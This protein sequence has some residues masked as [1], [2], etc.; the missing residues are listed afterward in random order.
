[1]QAPS[2]TSR[3]PI[4][5]LMAGAKRARGV[6]PPL[7]VPS[8]VV[9][10]E[11]C[12]KLTCS[13]SPGAQMESKGVPRHSAR[14]TLA[15]TVTDRLG[16]D[17]E[18]IRGCGTISSRVGSALGNTAFYSHRHS[19]AA[20]LQCNLLDVVVQYGKVDH[21][22]AQSLAEY[23]RSRRRCSG[24]PSHQTCAATGGSCS[25]CPESRSILPTQPRQ[26]AEV[27]KAVNEAPQ[28]QPMHQAKATAIKKISTGTPLEWLWELRSL[29]S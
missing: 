10:D 29:S 25:R 23:C 9:K 8:L 2:S 14:G 5:A 4:P 7:K 27:T 16:D 6:Q 15:L 1:M 3:A 21:S 12:P 28:Q 19:A 18:A 20:Q 24:R 26:E 13:S 11:R 17:T 22:C